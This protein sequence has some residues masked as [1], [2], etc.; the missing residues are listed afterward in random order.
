MKKG[1]T[2]EE[3]IDWALSRGWEK[4]RYSHLQK[5]LHKE[6]IKEIRKYR[7]KLSNISVRYE[8]R[9]RIPAT[10]YSP[11]SNAW[12]RLQSGYFKDLSINEHGQLVGLK[13]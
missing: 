11:A 9:V 7:F 4:D 5:E 8:V 12:V 1:L 10:T 13:R 6:K 3:F 2:K